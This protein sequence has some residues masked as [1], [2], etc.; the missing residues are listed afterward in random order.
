MLITWGSEPNSRLEEIARTVVETPFTRRAWSELLFLMVGMPIAFI[1]IAFVGI[2]MAAGVVLAITLDRDRPHRRGGAIGPWLRANAAKA[3]RRA[4]R[5]G[6]RR[7]RTVRATT[8]L[9]GMAAV[10][11]S[12]PR[13]AG[14]RWPTW[15]SKCRCPSWPSSPPSV[16]GGMHSDT[17]PIPSGGPA[18][19]VD[20]GVGGRPL[21][22]QPGYLSPGNSTPF[23]ALATVI[24]G[25]IFFFAAPWPVRFFD[26][27]D[28]LLMRTL[29]APDAMTVRVRKPRAGPDA[30]G[31]RLGR[32]PAE[33]RAGSP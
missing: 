6:H 14:G 7:A 29:L 8:G 13:R 1:G 33:D 2:T 22:F 19:A 11:S 26:Y 18:I 32:H 31:R 25:V 21:L 4:A 27:L 17:S 3:G 20:R 24:T 23:V 30:D 10:G 5:R 16:S 9:P 15:P 28:R 12:G